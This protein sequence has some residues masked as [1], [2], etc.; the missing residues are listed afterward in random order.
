MLD[1]D[2]SME[3]LLNSSINQFEKYLEDKDIEMENNLLLQQNKYLKVSLDQ[4]KLILKDKLE[5]ALKKQKE[6]LTVMLEDYIK[7]ITKLLKDKEDL[8]INIE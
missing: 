5:N 8:T 1:A 7:L 4:L 3:E 6:E 2:N